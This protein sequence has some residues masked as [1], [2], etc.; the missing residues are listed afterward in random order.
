MH[1][2]NCIEQ[3][4]N[5]LAFR[6]ETRG[7]LNLLDFNLHSENLYVHFCNEL[8]D[9]QLKN[10]NIDKQNAEAIDLVDH[11]NKIVVQVSATS[12]K[13]KVEAALSKDLSAFRE[14]SFKFI[15]I[16]KDASSLRGKTFANP[17][18]LLFVPQQDIY[19]VAS[20]LRYISSLS[21]DKMK[22]IESILR[23]EIKTDAS[24]VKLESNLATVINILAKENLATIDTQPET[25][26]F[27]IVDKIEFN[28]LRDRRDLI[29]DCHVYCGIIDRIYSDY[30]REGCNKSMSVLNSIK[31][32]YRVHA[33]L[34]SGHNLFDKVIE[35]VVERVTQSPNFANIPVE[36][37]EQC[38]HI[39]VVDT[40][41]RCKI[42]KRPIG[43]S[44]ASA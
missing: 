20:I 18:S 23:K 41:I 44:H 38:V 40:F 21:I 42:F 6:I 13:Q 25:I 43:H 33:H 19:D 15:A 1:Y 24:P 22:K 11:N 5:F 17:H 36:E 2:F 26:S 31:Y 16:S 37:L 30:D 4:L 12:T 32:F 3:R 29:E 14:Y 28:D 8:F 9:W 34:M 39:L 7:K 35:C 10:M 27:G